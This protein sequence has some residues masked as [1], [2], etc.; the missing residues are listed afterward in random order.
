MKSFRSV[1][2]PLVVIGALNTGLVGLMGLNLVSSVFG[3][4]SMLEKV[5]YLLV[6]LA[7]L[8]VAWEKWGGSKKK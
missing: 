5:V 7:G 1:T 6:G 3:T 2:L 4:G 8:L